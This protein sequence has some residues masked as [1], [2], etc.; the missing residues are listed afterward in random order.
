MRIAGKSLPGFFVKNTVKNNNNRATGND[1]V[2]FHQNIAG[3]LNKIDS[4][5]ICFNEFSE[6]CNALSIA[7]FSETF[8]RAGDEHLLVFK[9]YKYGCSF[10]RS[11]EKRGGVCTVA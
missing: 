3:L 10:S 6:N 2:L 5:E 9:N 11:N 8:V 7:C 1:L 4:V